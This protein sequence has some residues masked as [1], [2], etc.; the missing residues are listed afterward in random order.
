M[1]LPDTFRH[2]SLLLLLLAGSTG[3]AWAAPFTPAS[4]A[5]VLE[6][7]PGRAA[8][9]RM[10]DLREMRAAWARQPKDVDLAVRLARR[11]YEEVAAEGDPRWVGYAQA[12]LAPWWEAETPPPRVRVMRAVLRQ[13][14]HDFDSA[15]ADLQG[16]ASQ[17]PSLGE[18]WAWQAAIHMVR[19][20]YAAARRACEQLAPLA[21]PL[22]GV[23]CAASADSLSGQAEG[24]AKAL[25]AALATAPN[26]EPPERLWALTRLA[27]IEERLGR[28]REAEDAFRQAAALG[29]SDN[30]LLAAYADF[31]LDRRRPAD[32]LT[33][34][35]GKG[36]SDTL[37][38]RLVLAATQLKDPR[39]SQ[40]QADLAARFDDARRGRTT[41]EKEE[42]RFLM[43]VRND[44]ARA[45]R[46]ARH[47]FEVQREPADARVLLEAAIANRDR[48]AAR[49]VLEWMARS[50]VQSVALQALADTVKGL[51]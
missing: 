49:P 50:G 17:D 42:A 46:L 24:A 37:L 21:S 8:P 2:I 22:I 44:N 20:D 45:L 18:A 13:F 32:V 23:A 26:A 27:E 10:S 47:N 34:L 41:H 36:R 15:L 48:A 7:L 35:D 30:Y 29:L 11:Y 1:R 6:T 28:F 25:R 39:A 51:P 38:L 12:V 40:W 31:L 19:A 33:L 9:A 3:A 4:D 14:N 16:A 5:E 43:A